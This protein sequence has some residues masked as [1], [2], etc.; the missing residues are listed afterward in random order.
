VHRPVGRK[1]RMRTVIFD[2]GETLV[3]ETRQWETVARVAGIPS[4][5]LMAAIGGVIERREEHRAAFGDLGI[6]PVGMA[7]TDYVVGVEDFYPD[8]LPTLRTLKEAGYPVGIVANQP[9]GVAEQLAAMDLELDIIA[10]S[11]TY[12]VAKPDPRFFERIAADC[13][14]PPGEI[15]YV[16]D[17]L[18]N[19]VLPAQSIGMRAVFLRRGPWGYA[20]ARWPEASTV[21]YRIDTLTELP[22]LLAAMG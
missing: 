9:D 13:G 22:T 15:V 3:D 8:A 21:P 16:G 4:L 20:H 1:I 19:D 11:A 10:T 5:T 12:G 2:L 7:D 17:R 6:S 18:D 14:R